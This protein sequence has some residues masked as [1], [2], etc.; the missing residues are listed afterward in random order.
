MFKLK[1]G[2]YFKNNFEINH[3]GF[4]WLDRRGEGAGIVG[5]E[6]VSKGCVGFFAN[7]RLKRA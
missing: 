6:Y 2:T 4:N 5:G 1:S 7:R 3:H